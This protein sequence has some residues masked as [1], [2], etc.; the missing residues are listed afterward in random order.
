MLNLLAPPNRE[1][2][3]AVW[4][5]AVEDTSN[6]LRSIHVQAINIADYSMLLYAV[7][8]NQFDMVQFLIDRG[9]DVNELHNQSGTPLHIAGKI[10]NDVLLKLL[11]VSGVDPNIV[12]DSGITPLAVA[13]YFNNFEAAKALLKRGP[14]VTTQCLYNR[15]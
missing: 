10:K 14:L 3:Y 11:L 12:T 9:A 5:G 1:V 13:S 15:F 6:W 4:A 8:N 2:F 7:T